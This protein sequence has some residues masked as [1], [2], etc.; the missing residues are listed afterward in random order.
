MSDFSDLLFVWGET[1][2]WVPTVRPGELA[3]W[4]GAWPVVLGCEMLHWDSG[5]GPSKAQQARLRAARAVLV[6]LFGTS[7]HVEQVRAANPRAF[8]VAMPDPPV[9][10]VLRDEPEAILGQMAQADLIAGRT[11][12]DCAVYGALFDKPTVWLPSP[13]GPAD[14]FRALW[15]TP[16]A[17]VL[18][19]AEHNGIRAT[20][21]ATIAALAAVQRETGW[22]VHFYRASERTRHLAQLAGLQ[23]EW[24]EAVKF[25]EMA[26]AT[27]AARW[28]VDLYPFHAQGRNLLTH[29]MAGTPVVGSCTNNPAGAVEVGPY[30]PDAVASHILAMTGARY[31][32]HRR[33]AFDYV[34]ATYGFEASRARVAGILEA[35]L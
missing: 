16:K 15:D 24:K 17:D 18:I 14:A 27:A 8:I 12:H 9:E 10:Y 22:P 32:A 6:N 11:Q 2:P 23:V 33:R 34:E 13:I 35:A 5:R 3:C 4:V 26:R 28:G 25:P 29:A 31:E 20:S 19:A 1:G 7:R 30:R 21:G